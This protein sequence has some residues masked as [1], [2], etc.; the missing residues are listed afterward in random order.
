VRKLQAKEMPKGDNV[1]H[2]ERYIYRYKVGLRAGKLNVIS[3]HIKD[4]KNLKVLDVACGCGVF[5]SF[6]NE[7][8]A[9]T[10]AID[11]SKVMVKNVHQTDKGILLTQTSGENLP[12][13][14]NVFDVVLALDVIEHLHNPIQFLNEIHRVMKEN[15]V[16]LLTTDNTQF[17]FMRFFWIYRSLSWRVRKNVAKEPKQKLPSTHIKDYSVD[18]IIR[19][20]QNA[21]FAISEYDTYIS[22]LSPNSSF[23]PVKC[24]FDT[25]FRGNL[26]R[27]KWNSV[28]LLCTCTR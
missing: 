13:R 25:I 2:L 11:I 22:A 20:L 18:E 14:N 23:S 17:L 1:Q 21:N 4:I 28:F 8:G 3:K 6:C 5:S 10:Y 15:G 24:V 26:R 19:L 7:K 12:F 9:F 16:L 27:Y